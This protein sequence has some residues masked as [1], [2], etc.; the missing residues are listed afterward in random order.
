MRK[1]WSIFYVNTNSKR[2]LTRHTV[3]TR[4]HRISTCYKLKE[5][6]RVHRFPFLEEV[7]AA[8]TRA[9]RGLNKSGRF[10]LKCDG[11]R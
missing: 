1:L 3:Q 8:V 5:P 11:T 2:Y 9:I 10:Q 6:M 7:S 4:V